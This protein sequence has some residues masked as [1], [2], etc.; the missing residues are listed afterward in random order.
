MCR[1]RPA[2]DHEPVADKDDVVP[3]RAVVARTPEG[4]LVGK[5]GVAALSSVDLVGP[6]PKANKPA[7]PS[8]R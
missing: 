7:R 1:D 4:G 2:S 5:F 8:V 6:T 3:V